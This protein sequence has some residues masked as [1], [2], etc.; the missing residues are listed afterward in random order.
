MMSHN[1]PLQQTG[2]AL[3]FWR[4]LCLPPASLLNFVV[5]RNLTV[6]HGPRPIA[7][8]SDPRP[9]PCWTAVATCQAATT[10][11]GCGTAV[12]SGPAGWLWWKRSNTTGG[13]AR[14]PRLVRLGH[15]A[16]PPDRVPVVREGAVHY[17]SDTVGEVG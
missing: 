14:R 12:R 13:P 10:R 9:F 6:A 8:A 15:S 1:Q 17:L 16:Q 7:R 3:R 4:F 5:E 11:S 2:P